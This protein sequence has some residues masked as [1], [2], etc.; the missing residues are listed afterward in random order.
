MVARSGLLF[1]AAFL[2]GLAGPARV[3]C[4]EDIRVMISGALAASYTELIPEFERRTGHKLITI[5]AS[6]EGGAGDSIPERLKRNEIADLLV[7]GRASLNNLLKDG[8][9]VAGSEVDIVRS[10][11]GLAVRIGLPKPDIGTL[12]GLKRALL[13]AKSIAYSASVS[14]TYLSTEVFPRLGIAEQV[15]PKSKRIFSERVGAVLLRGEADLGMQQISELTPFGNKLQY[16]GPLPEGAQRITL[17]TAAISAN[18]PN[19]AAA[20]QLRDFL[21]SRDAHAAIRKFN[22]EPVSTTRDEQALAEAFAPTGTMRAIIN[23]GNPVLAKR[24]SEA[25]APT[26]VSVD[27]AN[28][29][30]RRLGVLVE[31]VVVTSA[32]KAVET[33]RAGNGDVGFF[34]IDP[35]RND[36]ITFSTPYI[37]IEGAFLV[38]EGSTLKSR[39]DVD[40]AGV[41]IAVGL[42]SAYDLFLTR[43]IKAATLVRVPTSPEVVSAFVG[44]NLDVAAGVKQQ[45]E[46][47]QAT[48]PGLRL[49]P[50]A[51]MT[52]NQAMGL[53][54]G[55]KP[56]AGTY[57]AKFVEDAK[58]SGFVRAALQRHG[59]AGAAVAP[60]GP[61]K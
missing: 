26:G 19:P 21:A 52:I 20:K 56:E 5:L 43:E 40:T 57:L 36:G 9:A 15:L 27:L 14:G 23:L 4:A 42:N 45:L 33:L 10:G 31:Y 29:L 24:T 59:I 39:D 25:A 3:A 22:L 55:R 61:A 6:S 18:S 32:G 53:P 51:F 49:L 17:F 7:M 35:M 30:A 8:K 13:D 44:Q 38:R 41:R 50:G 1:A 54:S 37:N 12:D 58:A 60:H 28:E 48:T 46:A 34:A 11:M 47:D 2:V 16:V